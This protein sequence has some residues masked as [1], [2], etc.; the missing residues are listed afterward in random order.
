MAAPSVSGITLLRDLDFIS[1]VP[2][3]ATGSVAL[4]SS[5]ADESIKFDNF[6]DANQREWIELDFASTQDLTDKIILFRI[7]I[8]M[9]IADDLDDNFRVGLFSQSNT[10]YVEWTLSDFVSGNGLGI[11]I[12]ASAT[13]DESAGTFDITSVVGVRFSVIPNTTSSGSNNSTLRF[14]FVNG[15]RSEIVVVDSLTLEGGE[16]GN[17][18]SFNT[19]S[20]ELGSSLYGFSEAG[21]G[22]YQGFDNFL[23]VAT[24]IT[25]ATDL[26]T[27][28]LGAIA[29]LPTSKLNRLIVI[30]NKRVLK[31]DNT[32]AQRFSA[33]TA[34]SPNTTDT[35]DFADE[36]GLANEYV[37]GT[38]DTPNEVDLGDKTW[39]RREIVNAQGTVS[40]GGDITSLSLNSV[41]SIAYKPA[42]T[43]TFSGGNEITG[44]PDHAISIESGQGFSNGGSL[45]L[46]TFDLSGVTPGTNMFRVDIGASAA[47]TITV[48]A[49][50]SLT[51]SDVTAV[52]SET[53]TVIAPRPTLT[54]NGFVDG[55]TVIVSYAGQTRA[56][57]NNA[58]PPFSYEVSTEILLPSSFNVR[59]ER[60]GFETYTQSVQI[61]ESDVSITVAQTPEGASD[62]Y[63]T[64]QVEF[65]A[66]MMDDVGF[67]RIIVGATA[68]L[69]DEAQ[70]VRLANFTNADVRAAW[71]LLV[72]ETV[73]T[74]QEITDWQGYLT[75]TGYDAVSFDNSS[76]EAS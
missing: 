32:S 39:T 70:A 25:I 38:F 33:L 2:S 34:V 11:A 27:D 58:S 15:S 16:V 62:T 36:S 68:V 19:I 18:A 75:A 3:W 65:Q 50:S 17:T 67:Q 22:N 1:T 52:N 9:N 44:T 41:A 53:V 66:L 31:V 73:P 43:T 54:I 5:N 71:N 59:I 24:S 72:A 56:I 40:N 4:A 55:S 42:S 12:D 64:A 23:S 48:P 30:G 63:N 20:T 8:Q 6:P 21:V 49:G 61:V 37:G 51:S 14:E 29:F 69:A 60:T 13:P 46:S 35:F 74:S 57:L 45:D 10:D 26:Y 7:I 47:F 76:G 28:S